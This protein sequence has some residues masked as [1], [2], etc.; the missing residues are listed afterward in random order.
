MFDA[1]RLEWLEF[2]GAFV[3]NAPAVP[4]AASR[5]RDPDGTL[6]YESWKISIYSRGNACRA[7]L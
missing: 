7:S 1:L 4:T 5:C 3:Y 6:I 2:S